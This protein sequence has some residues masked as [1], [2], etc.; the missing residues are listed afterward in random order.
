MTDKISANELRQHIEAIERLEEEKAGIN[1][2]IKDRYA[3]PKST[4]FD[5]KTMRRIIARRKMEQHQATE[6]DVLFA[7][8]AAALGMQLAFDI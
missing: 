2:D 8:Y 1:D 3:L 6:S 7:T 5:V 4:G